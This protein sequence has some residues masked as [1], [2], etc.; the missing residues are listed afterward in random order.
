MGTKDKPPKGYR[1]GIVAYIRLTNDER[2]ALT[3]HYW[4]EWENNPSYTEYKRIQKEI[5]QQQQEAQEYFDKKIFPM[6]AEEERLELVGLGFCGVH[7]NSDGETICM[8]GEKALQNY[9]DYKNAMIQKYSK[10]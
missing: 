9:M 2:R 1:E 8:M 3:E 4:K 5:H 7:Y 10:P 6:M